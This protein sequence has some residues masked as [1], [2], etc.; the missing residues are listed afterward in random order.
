MGRIIAIDYGL[1]RTGIAV[2]DPMKIIASPLC[3]IETKNLM[4]W[5]EKY[6]AIEPVDTIVVGIATQPDGKETHTTQPAR[7][8]V[9]KLTEK[10]KN[11]SVY[12]E[13]E[14]YTSKMAL[15][16]MIAGGTKKSD[17]RDKGKI[18]KI[19]AA[20][21]LQSFMAKKLT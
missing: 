17:R 7:Q 3:A 8:L 19:S 11:I 6:L 12:T 4:T 20:I 13:D 21:I 10:F 1:K 18:D 2:T 14:R 16:S 5:L 15:Q 9:G